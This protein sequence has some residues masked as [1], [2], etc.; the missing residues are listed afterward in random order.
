[1]PDTPAFMHV[2]SYF[3]TWSGPVAWSSG[4]LENLREFEG[5]VLIVSHDRYSLKHLATRVFE[6]T[7]GLMNTTSKRAGI[8][9]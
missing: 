1:M 8:W 3:Q 7:S 4:G 9:G 2:M 6:S 5:A